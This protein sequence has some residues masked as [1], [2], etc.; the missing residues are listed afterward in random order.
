[1]KLPKW[2]RHARTGQSLGFSCEHSSLVALVCNSHTGYVSPQYHVVFDNTFSIVFNDGKSS[3]E[4]VKICAGCLFQAGS[5]LSRT[6][7]MKM[8]CWFINHHR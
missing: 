2:N 3:A 7:M 8:I 1:M 5:A 4:L 6:S